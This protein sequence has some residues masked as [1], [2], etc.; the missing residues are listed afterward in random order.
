MSDSYRSTG[1]RVLEQW[2]WIEDDDDLFIAAKLLSYDSGEAIFEKIDGTTVTHPASIMSEMDAAEKC[3][4][5]DDYDLMELSDFDQ[6]QILHHLRKRFRDG[7]IFTEIGDIL[8]TM[9]SQKEIEGLFTKEQMDEYKLHTD[10]TDAE[11][12]IY[13]FAQKAYHMLKDSKESQSLIIAGESGSGATFTQHKIIEYFLS[14]VPNGL[15]RGDL[16]QKIPVAISILECFGSASTERH[17]QASQFGIWINLSIHKDTKKIVGCGFKDYLLHTYRLKE[18]PMECAKERA[19]DALELI[20][21]QVEGS[22]ECRFL[23]PPNEE[24][25]GAITMTFEELKRKFESLGCN[26]LDIKDIMKILKAIIQIG[27]IVVEN[28]RFDDKDKATLEAIYE[29]LGIDGEKKGMF[30]EMILESQIQVTS[31]NISMPSKQQHAIQMLDKTAQFLYLALFKYLFVNFSFI[32]RRDQKIESEQQLSLGICNFP[33]FEV[34][35][36]GNDFIELMESWAAERMEELYLR[37]VF[38][39]EL[40][41]FK[42]EKV[43]VRSLLSQSA[44]QQTME[45]SWAVLKMLEQPQNGIMS[46]IDRH[47]SLWRSLDSDDDSLLRELNEKN[48]ADPMYES[49]GNDGFIIHHFGGKT[50]YDITDFIKKNDDFYP[51]TMAQVFLESKDN[52]VLDEAVNFFITT[53]KFSR[54]SENEQTFIKHFGRELNDLMDRIRKS[55]PHYIRCFRINDGSGPEHFDSKLVF[56]QME[57]AGM[58]HVVKVRNLGLPFRFPKPNFVKRYVGMHPSAKTREDV[59][60][61]AADFN[62]VTKELVDKFWSLSGLSSDCRLQAGVNHVFMTEDLYSEMERMRDKFIKRK[63]LKAIS[64]IKIINN[65]KQRKK[66][67]NNLKVLKM[68]IRNNASAQLEG[69]LQELKEFECPMELKDAIMK[70]HLVLK[71]AEM[72]GFELPSDEPTIEEVSVEYV[73]DEYSAAGQARRRRTGSLSLAMQRDDYRSSIAMLDN[74]L[75]SIVEG[76]A[77]AIAEVER[78]YQRKIDILTAQLAEAQKRSIGQAVCQDDLNEAADLEERLQRFEVDDGLSE[79]GL[80]ECPEIEGITVDIEPPPEPE[81]E[82]DEED[83]AEDD[84]DGDEDGEKADGDDEDA[85]ED[86]AGAEDEDGTAEDGE[87][88]VEDPDVVK[89][90]KFKKL[91]AAVY[92]QLS[93]YNVAVR[94]AQDLLRNQEAF[95]KEHE[96]QQRMKPFERE[97]Q[98]EGLDE[99]HI[100]LDEL[101]LAI[102][103]WADLGDIRSE[104]KSVLHMDYTPIVPVYMHKQNKLVL[105]SILN[106]PV[107]IKAWNRPIDVAGTDRGTSNSY[108]KSP[109]STK[110]RSTT[111]RSHYKKKSPIS[112][113]QSKKKEPERTPV[114]NFQRSGGLFDETN[115]TEVKLAAFVP[116]HIPK[117]L[118]AVVD[119]DHNPLDFMDAF[120]QHQFDSSENIDADNNPLDG[121]NAF[122]LSSPYSPKKRSRSRSSTSLRLAV[123]ETKALISTLSKKYPNAS[124]TPTGTDDQRGLTLPSTYSKSR[125]KT[126]SDRYTSSGL[127]LSGDGSTSR[128]RPTPQ[129]YG[130]GNP[131]DLVCMLLQ[132]VDVVLDPENH[133][134]SKLHRLPATTTIAVDKIKYFGD[135]EYVRI[136]QPESGW[137]LTKDDNGNSNIPVLSP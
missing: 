135:K 2:F 123:R 58:H 41:G 11:P 112:R 88:S 79:M 114:F 124:A 89:T 76:S 48:E 50:K 64:M 60:N 7:R 98:V 119:A 47:T 21:E 128:T 12:H 71:A 14:V 93:D 20:R 95:K 80:S 9:N 38:N 136:S 39:D 24:T 116:S 117:R 131:M 4:L 18:F 125:S 31:R 26:Q 121:L 126:R 118:G 75:E 94:I 66:I 33:G 32:F 51:A 52:E 3:V 68:G 96:Q 109:K 129:E 99:L 105:D 13:G 120:G 100:G 133:P 73:P 45:S 130:G 49:N 43:S 44:M 137:I 69:P 30:M 37:D 61:E 6:R 106:A 91:A 85:G 81:D 67:I 34:S 27:R 63:L 5:A 56:K 42:K 40:D 35:E 103:S 97:C 65:G 29:L 59:R 77:T 55:N 87:K 15:E 101:N 10:D 127:T 90:E 62:K 8:V 53:T 22:E 23:P 122:G 16:L 83:E 111:S 115:E 134:G 110:S 74:K 78:K 132:D 46:I 107:T 72:C 36:E 86:G 104:N 1:F 113:T 19:F 82:E 17:S 54:E 108:R 92:E 84:N 102:K 28:G 70:H 25:A 57:S